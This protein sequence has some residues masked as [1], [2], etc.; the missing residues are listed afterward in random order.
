M[1]RSILAI[2]VGFVLTG[3]LNVGTQMLL[4]GMAPE[5][6]PAAGTPNFDTTSLILISAYVALYGILGCYVTA[7]LAPSRPLLHALVMGA[8]ALVMSIAMTIP[9]WSN[10]PAW[11]NVYNL[12]AVMPYAYLGG[13]IR[14]RELERGGQGRLAVS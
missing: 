13:R 9:A 12:L 1:G 14:E 2:V 10:A 5:T 6:F 3:A 11:F 4:S 7:R 8:L